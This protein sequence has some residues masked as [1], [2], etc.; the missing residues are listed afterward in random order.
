M[1]KKDYVKLAKE[2]KYLLTAPCDN[3]SEYDG[4]IATINATIRVLKE[5]N[6]LFNESIFKKACGLV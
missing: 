3:Q 4:I 6:P 2:Y 5:D 1:T